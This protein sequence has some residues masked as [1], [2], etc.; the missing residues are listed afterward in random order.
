[1]RKIRLVA[2]QSPPKTTTFK[3]LFLLVIGCCIST[4]LFYIWTQYKTQQL[5][6]QL[7]AE[8]S[9]IQITLDKLKV[10]PSPS[11]QQKDSVVQL[12]LLD[13]LL[14]A[15]TPEVLFNHIQLDQKNLLQVEGIAPSALAIGIFINN[16]QQ[17]GLMLHIQQV[18]VD[19]QGQVRFTIQQG[20][21]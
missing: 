12:N 5:R 19:E 21:A 9:N 3:I 7:I 6:A 2:L 10:I 18:S 20:A 15:R 1:M 16:A 13:N 14:R 17:Q 8:Q 4:L 11:T